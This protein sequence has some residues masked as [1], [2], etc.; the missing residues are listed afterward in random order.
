MREEISFIEA[1]EYPAKPQ[2][3]FL[4]W[5]LDSKAQEEKNYDVDDILPVMPRNNPY[6]RGQYIQPDMPHF[7][8]MATRFV[9]YPKQPIP[10]GE[11]RA[12]P[13]RPDVIARVPKYVPEEPLP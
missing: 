8:F 1:D 2:H 4:S 3:Q 5:P 10:N 7:A 6:N 12:P 9:K 11:L 13:P